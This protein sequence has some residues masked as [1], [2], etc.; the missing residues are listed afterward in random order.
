M[1]PALNIL[2]TVPWRLIAVAASAA[3][4]FCGG[5]QFGANRVNARWDAEK[6]ATAQA[7]VK[8]AT[9]VAA[10]NVQ[11]S[12]INQEISDE[13]QKA[14]ATIAA[15]DLH[16]LARVPYRVRIALTGS[17]C[18]MP[19]VPIGASSADAAPADPI[20]SPEQPTTSANCQKLAE[21]AAQTTLMVVEFQRWYRE[22]AAAVG[23]EVRRGRGDQP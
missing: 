6:I 9:H 13:F 21:D 1:F 12:T 19:S 15:N 5:C 18:T 17:A 16:L 14:K 20:S 2:A 4:L 8:Q 7:V 10:V 22:Q 3:A 23:D 11:Q